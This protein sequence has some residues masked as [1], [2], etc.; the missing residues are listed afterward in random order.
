LR[1][2]KLEKRGKRLDEKKQ[3]EE[4]LDE[5]R[6]EMM[7]KSFTTKGLSRQLEEKTNKLEDDLH[8][9]QERHSRLQNDFEDKVQNEKRLQERLRVLEKEGAAEHKQLQRK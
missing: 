2:R 7:N 9:M 3:A 6:D 1:S 8:E 5:L 4:N